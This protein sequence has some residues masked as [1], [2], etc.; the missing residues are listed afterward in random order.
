VPAVQADHVRRFVSDREP[1]LFD[2]EGC[3][4]CWI[5]RLNQNIGA[6][7]VCHVCFS[8]TALAVY[9]QLQRRSEKKLVDIENP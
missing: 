5:L 3:R 8:R 4:A 7:S 9:T 1:E 2:L 6:K